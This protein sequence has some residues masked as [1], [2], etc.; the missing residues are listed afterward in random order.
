MQQDPAQDVTLVS[1]T[2]DEGE[3]CLGKQGRNKWKFPCS[4]RREGQ[5]QKRKKEAEEE[6]L[7]RKDKLDLVGMH[8]PFFPGPS[9]GATAQETWLLAPQVTSTL[10]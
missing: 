2:G 9:E 8:H 4:R 1:G 10:S 5:G 7:C 3:K 6:K